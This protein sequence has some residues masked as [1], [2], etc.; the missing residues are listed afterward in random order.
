MVADDAASY[1]TSGHLSHQ[2]MQ[3][4][5]RELQEHFLEEQRLRQELAEMGW[6]LEQSLR[7]LKA[8]NY[9]FQEH[10]GQRFA[11][12]EAYQE[13]LEGLQ[14][15]IQ[16]TSPLAERTQS[17]PLPDLQGTVDPD[18]DRGSIQGDE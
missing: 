8:L 1:R 14:R 5:A 12:G 16:E 18:P 11:V 4:Y 3:I 2:Q 9:L 7:E 10:L 17:Q 15:L 13:L 6:H